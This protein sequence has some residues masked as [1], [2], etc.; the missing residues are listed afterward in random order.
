MPASNALALNL[1][2]GETEQARLVRAVG[3]TLAGALLMAVAAQVRI[4][5]WPVPLTMQTFAVLLVAGTYTAPLAFSSMLLYVVLG[6]VGAPIFS[7]GNAGWAYFTGTTF[8]YLIGFIV[9]ATVAGRMVESGYGRSVGWLLVVF[10]VAEA[11]I[12]ALGVA[13]LATIIGLPGAIEHGLIPFLIGDALKAALA[14]ALIAAGW[15]LT[16]R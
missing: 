9:A 10:L 12:F 15:R 6:A 8:G 4:P 2:R 13:W 3:L 1:W 11:I 14:I 16:R 7:D 5:F